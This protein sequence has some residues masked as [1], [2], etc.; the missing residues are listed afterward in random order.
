[1]CGIAVIIEARP[2]LTDSAIERMTEC[3][4][5]RGPDAFGTVNVQGARLG[6]RRL[7]IIDLSGGAQPM[8]DPTERFW[9]AWM[10]PPEP[11]ALYWIV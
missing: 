5:H 2:G 4:S 9:I 1:M 7:S 8:A 11:T 10:P 3:L 6:H